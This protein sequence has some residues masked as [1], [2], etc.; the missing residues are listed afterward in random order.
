MN[1][2]II[3][4]E[5]QQCDALLCGEVSRVNFIG[6]N[7]E[8]LGL[9]QES[10]E[11]GDARGQVLYGLCFFY[12]Q[13]VDESEERAIEWFRKSADQGNAHA[14]TS[15][16]LCYKHGWG[17]EQDEELALPWFQKA[18]EQG[19]SLAAKNMGHLTKEI[20][21][22]LAADHRYGGM[23]LGEFK[24]IDDDAAEFLGT[25]KFRSRCDLCFDGLTELSANAA[26]GLAAF[27]GA[28]RFN[29]DLTSLSDA[30][31]ENLSQHRGGELKLGGLTELSAA[32]AESFGKY[33]GT[34]DFTCCNL[35]DG[36]L[37][38]FGLATLSD[39]AAEGLSKHQGPLK[40]PG[41][42]ELSD[43]AVQSLGRHTGT[44]ELDGLTSLSNAAAQSLS[45]HSG[46]L[47]LGGLTE[48]SDQLL[49]SLSGNPEVQL[50]LGNLKSLS[51]T[52]AERLSREQS[53]RLNLKGLTSLSDAAAESLSKHE[54]EELILDGL[55]ILSDQAAESLSQYQGRV[56]LAGLT[57]L[58]DAAA[59]SLSKCQGGLDLSGLTTISE[60]L[61][62]HFVWRILEDADLRLPSLS[63]LNKRRGQ[64]CKISQR[65]TILA[66]RREAWAELRTNLE[67]V[68][69]AV[70]DAHDETNP[71]RIYDSLSRHEFVCGIAARGGVL[72]YDLAE[73]FG[74]LGW[75]YREDLLD[76]CVA[77]D[78]NAA[79]YLRDECD[80]DLGEMDLSFPNLTTL[81]DAAAES[82]AAYEAGLEIDLNNLPESAAA[83]LRHHPSFADEG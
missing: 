9:W 8:R 61:L 52:S 21:E 41:L 37:R 17:V 11:A 22:Q 3:R 39:A 70:S 20:A 5:F 74:N 63:E 48:L 29:R 57:N 79:D 26:K 83:I 47:K 54:G 24:T 59:E 68:A 53:S 45:K 46:P 66:A 23:L 71:G 27:G 50:E 7:I 75:D 18:A 25:Y 2:E 12:G 51:D 72:T 55:S 81:S 56:S 10:A 36:E 64:G 69:D 49:E 76:L 62:G 28:I 14:Q 73:T 78:D 19:H 34:L 4:E 15:L 1:D 13:G 16:G 30:A 38:Q 42:T 77:I 44:L 31:A 80:C 82:L 40:L 32:A 35:V 6:S 67:S 60:T 43:A 58:S 33:E 65:A